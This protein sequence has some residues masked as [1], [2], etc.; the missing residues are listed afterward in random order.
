MVKLLVPDPSL[1][2]LIG[3]SGS[4]KSTFAAKHFRNTEVISSDECRALVSDDEN[5]QAATPAA[6]RILHAVARERLRSRHMTVID[7]TNVQPRSR[8]PLVAMAR[9]FGV[10]AVAV[11]FDLPE[12]LCLERNRSRP[13]RSLP[14]DVI[15][16]QREQMQQSA[17]G[18][19]DEGFASICVLDSADAI[20]A[21]VVSRQP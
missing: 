21:A 6:F 7:A 11:V 16:R 18:L 1:V 13:S 9:K 8:K 12:Q 5:N 14:P 17:S 3:P 10:P 2:V 4:G 20:D 19:S 15:H